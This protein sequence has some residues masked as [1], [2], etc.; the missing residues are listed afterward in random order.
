MAEQN[1]PYISR[2]SQKQAAVIT[3]DEFVKQWSVLFERAS[4]TPARML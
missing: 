1:T 2:I 3:F 4:F